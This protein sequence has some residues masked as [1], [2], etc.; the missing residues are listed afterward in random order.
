MA[1]AVRQVYPKREQMEIKD[2]TCIFTLVN[3]VKQMYPTSASSGRGSAS[4]GHAALP[5]MRR[6]AQMAQKGGLKC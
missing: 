5:R 3:Q 4:A 6:A 1:C 2:Y